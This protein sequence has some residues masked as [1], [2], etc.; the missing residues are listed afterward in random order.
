MVAGPPTSEWRNRF[1]ISASLLGSR[2]FSNPATGGGSGGGGGTQQG[3][4]F[5][6]GGE[7]NAIA[8]G[9]GWNA[10]ERHAAAIKHIMPG[11]KTALIMPEARVNYGDVIRVMDRLKLLEI[12]EIGIAPL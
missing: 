7:H 11:L 6:G 8:D 3:S 5:L 4:N 9:T 12:G 2:R 1:W 10:I